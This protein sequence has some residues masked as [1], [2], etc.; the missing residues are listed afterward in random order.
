MVNKDL[1]NGI[2]V[3]P[4]LVNTY[5]IGISQANNPGRYLP[6]K[7][8][9]IDIFLANESLT[10]DD[11]ASGGQEYVVSSDGLGPS[12]HHNSSSNKDLSYVLSDIPMCMLGND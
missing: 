12:R 2:L 6:S 3:G 9:L 1:A 10:N 11:L 5:S 8:P 7:N 4:S